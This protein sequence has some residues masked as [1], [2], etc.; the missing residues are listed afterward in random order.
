M[1]NP[2][3]VIKSAN[4]RIKEIQRI[5]EEHKIDGDSA[6]LHQQLKELDF[7]KNQIKSL[8]LLKIEKLIDFKKFKAQEL[9]ETSGMPD[10]PSLAAMIEKARENGA[11][12]FD[13]YPRPALIHGQIAKYASAFSIKENTAQM[14]RE[15]EPANIEEQ[16]KDDQQAGAGMLSEESTTTD[17]QTSIPDESAEP[18][19]APQ[20]TAIAP[21]A[22]VPADPKKTEKPHQVVKTGKGKR[23]YKPPMNA[24]R[25]ITEELEYQDKLL[26]IRDN[27]PAYLFVDIVSAGYFNYAHGITPGMQKALGQAGIKTMNDLRQHTASSL[28]KFAGL[29][30]AKVQVLFEVLEPNGLILFN[31]MQNHDLVAEQVKKGMKWYSSITDKK[32]RKTHKEEAVDQPSDIQAASPTSSEIPSSAA[33]ET[34]DQERERRILKKVGEMLENKKEIFLMSLFEYEQQVKRKTSLIRFASNAHLLLGDIAVMSKK[35][36]FDLNVSRDSVEEI[37]TELRQAGLRLGL[38]QEAEELLRK[39]EKY[40]QEIHA[41]QTYYTNAF[42][43]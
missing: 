31:E 13:D 12:F 21:T 33:I 35:D 4:G 16:H 14:V 22:E 25:T 18:E 29:G 34:D 30:D 8:K 19:K 24:I 40:L 39:E 15:T 20:Q 6:Y 43:L 36:L 1:R 17:D 11:W 27:F 23:S 9:H 10:K 2:P 37:D 3:Y 5:E 42:E 41:R 7:T 38:R 26:G 28:K 32:E